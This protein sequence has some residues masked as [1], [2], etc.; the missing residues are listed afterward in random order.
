MAVILIDKMKMTNK[1]FSIIFEKYQ[2]LNLM[3]LTDRLLF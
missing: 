3:L 1:Y 2:R